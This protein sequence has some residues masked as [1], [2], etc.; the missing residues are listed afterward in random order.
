MFE[1]ACE[2][3]GQYVVVVIVRKRTRKWKKVQETWY[4]II[5]CCLVT[6]MR[7]AV[8]V[9]LISDRKPMMPKSGRS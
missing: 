7:H 2:Y 4:V 8:S 5:D 1:F 6:R 9:P 3:Q